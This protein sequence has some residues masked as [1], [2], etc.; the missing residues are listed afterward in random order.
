M[1]VPQ[2]VL[3]HKTLMVALLAS[4]AEAAREL[5]VKVDMSVAE[6]ARALDAN[7]TAAYQQRQRL[8]EALQE[9]VAV[10]PGRPAATP[11]EGSSA[12]VQELALT[13][14]VLEFRTKHLDAVIEYE[15]RT[16]Y[17]PSF[18][19][20]ILGELDVWQGTHAQFAA[21]CRLP[22]D[23][24]KDWVSADE[25]GLER[26][27]GPERTEVVIPVDASETTRAILKA[28][29]EWQGS[30]RSFLRVAKGRFGHSPNQVARVLRICRAI[31]PRA[32][33]AYRY[34][35]SMHP[36]S[37]GAMLVTD[38]KTLDVELTASRRRINRNWQGI[39]D[40]TTGCHTALVVTLQ[41][42][43]SAVIRAFAE[44]VAFL[45]DVAPTGL[46]HD[47]KACY[48]SERLRRHVAKLGTWLVPATLR[49]PENKGG[50]ESA[51]SRF[52]DWVGTIRL[53][54]RTKE[55]L[56]DSAV[57]EVLRAFIAATNGVPRE[58][59]AGRSRLSAL[60]AARPSAAQQAADRAFIQALKERHERLQRSHWREKIKPAARRLLDQ[61]F[62][63][64]ALEDRD[65]SGKLRDFLATYEVAAIR[66]AA[67]IVASR[68]ERGHVQGEFAHRYLAKVI[69]AC[70]E[71]LDLERQEVVLL[72]LC[73]NG[74]QDWVATER[75]E[76]EQLK[77]DC[78]PL[79]LAC[80]LAEHAAEG[81]L[82]VAAAFWTER[83]LEYL[84]EARH[85]I[86]AVR[87]FLVRLYEAPADRRL[88]LIDRLAALECGVS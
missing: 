88:S 53:D 64:L 86:G 62:R 48:R 52:E 2:E 1:N 60:R 84:G 25:T 87:Q 44:S 85:L 45:G 10:R 81:G 19:R 40:Q 27:S 26:S 13:V 42:T 8:V 37:P 3:E 4:A 29:R 38:G 65:P 39:L 68:M 57:R 63:L 66:Q 75:E 35:H 82:P 28:F 7:R 71:S 41:E 6:L 16:S 67:A 31:K 30:T 78:G 77:S 74:A 69:Q 55:T 14:R 12:D 17:S 9:L 34:R 61:V 23:T 76:Y 21:A 79:A 58:E 22:A 32:R 47:G 72:E 24:L 36:L 33:R 50:L 18:R 56:I 20:F 70:Q 59:L 83:L 43:T 73:R 11:S 51:F 80:A 49:R 54:D 46:L 5:E 15:R